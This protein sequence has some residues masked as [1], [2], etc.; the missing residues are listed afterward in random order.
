M[1]LQRVQIDLVGPDEWPDGDEYDQFLANERL[2]KFLFRDHLRIVLH[3]LRSDMP[4]G[5]EVE[6]DSLRWGDKL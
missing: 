5:Y 6:A 2:V 4:E 1:I 3:Q